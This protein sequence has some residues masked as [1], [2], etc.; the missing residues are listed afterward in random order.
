VLLATNGLLDSKSLL[1]QLKSGD[2]IEYCIEIFAQPRDP[3]ASTPVARSE[4]R[5][6]TVMDEKAF[7]A[8]FQNLQDEDQRVKDLEKKQKGVFEPK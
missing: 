6:V 4:S 8:W 1:R 3:A 2:K 7:L 5:V